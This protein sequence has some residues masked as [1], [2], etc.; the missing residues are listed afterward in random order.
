M[1]PG[2]SFLVGCPEGLQL[3][4]MKNLHRAGGRHF[5]VLARR[6]DG[7]VRV[8]RVANEP[9]YGEAYDT[10]RAMS[11]NTQ[12]ALEKMAVGA[13]SEVNVAPQSDTLDVELG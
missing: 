9:T 12:Q 3:Q 4:V 13:Q 2:D 11:Q 5:R 1:E 7:G 10:A 6:V 8:W